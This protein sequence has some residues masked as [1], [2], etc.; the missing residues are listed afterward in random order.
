MPRIPVSRLP[1]PETDYS[2]LTLADLTR[3]S[4][5][6]V[7]AIEFLSHSNAPFAFDAM[8]EFDRSHSR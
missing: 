4:I 8:R 2:H 7:E 1:Y 5:N 3:D 6:R